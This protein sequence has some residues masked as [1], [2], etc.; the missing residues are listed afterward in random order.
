MIIKIIYRTSFGVISAMA[1]LVFLLSHCINNT[2]ID[3][4]ADGKDFE[5]YVGSE[6]VQAATRIFMKSICK[7]RI[8]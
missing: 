3:K 8:I 2:K 1:L 7:Q 6:N 4:E 5:N